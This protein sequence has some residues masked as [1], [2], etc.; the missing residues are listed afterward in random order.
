MEEHPFAQYVR[1]LGKGRSGARALSREEAYSAMDMIYRYDVEPE[2]IGAF[3]MLMRMK[4]ESAEEVAGFVQA[5]RDSIPL[6]PGNTRVA[7]DW[8]SYAGKRRQLPWYLLAALLLSRNGYPVFMHGLTRDDERLYTSQ[9]LQALGIEACQ[10]IPVAASRINT[11]GFAYLDIG[12]LSPLTAEL[13]DTRDLL[14][15]RSPLHTVVRMINPFSAPLSLHAVFHPNYAAIHQQAALL[16]GEKT[17]LSFKGEGGENERIPERS[18]TV[19]GVSDGKCWEQQWP[20]LL[21]PDKYGRESFPDLDHYLA[22]WKGRVED[23]YA[24]MAVLG[25]LALVL[26]A[27]EPGHTQE[28]ILQRA[29]LM[30]QTRNSSVMQEQYA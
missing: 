1:M 11:S 4:E 2:Q 7:V 25:T 18:C 16:L 21:P 20:P 17:A 26:S 10:S 27:L 15:L 12:Q 8:P 28:D 19:Y 6:L 24:V 29:Q 14:G 22:V 23:K 13:L 30:W 9:A 5:I 3:L